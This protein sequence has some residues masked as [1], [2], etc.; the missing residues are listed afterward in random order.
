MF[1]PGPGTYNAK[2]DASLLA[3]P[4]W[5]IGTSTRDD[6]DKQKMR[7]CNF[8]SSDTYNPEY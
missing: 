7:N 6:G 1:S 4:G 5:K 3:S 2:A 8:P